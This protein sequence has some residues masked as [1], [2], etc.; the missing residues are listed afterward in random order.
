[1]N[2][3]D[4]AKSGLDNGWL[5]FQESRVYFSVYFYFNGKGI[6]CDFED[7]DHVDGG[8]FVVFQIVKRALPVGLDLMAKNRLMGSNLCRTSDAEAINLLSIQTRARKTNS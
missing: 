1:M 7:A 2:G 6:G 5:Q 3:Y 4:E 8:N